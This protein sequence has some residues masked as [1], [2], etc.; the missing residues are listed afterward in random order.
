MDD[1]STL[2]LTLKLTGD[3]GLPQTL[4]AQLEGAVQ[5]WYPYAEIEAE[6]KLL[7]TWEDDEATYTVVITLTARGSARAALHL[8]HDLHVEGH[9]VTS[10]QVLLTCTEFNTVSS[11][12]NSR[13]MGFTNDPA[14]CWLFFGA[15]SLTPP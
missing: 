5:V 12:K 13:R 15:H 6:A 1:A 10:L 7:S 9:L 4:V 3:I 8:I 11:F 14:V 2:S